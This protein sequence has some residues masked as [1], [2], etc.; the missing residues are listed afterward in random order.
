M[1]S[2]AVTYS[3][4]QPFLD[5]LH[6]PPD[7]SSLWISDMNPASF[8]LSVW[9]RQR[10]TTGSIL[11]YLTN[12]FFFLIFHSAMLEISA[13]HQLQLVMFYCQL[14]T[15]SACPLPQLLSLIC[16]QTSGPWSSSLA[17]FQSSTSST[18]QHQHHGSALSIPSLNHTTQFKQ[19][20]RLGQDSVCVCVCVCVYAWVCVP[21]LP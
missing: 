15:K 1:Y 21:P 2:D 10:P 3:I 16:L 6:F 12:N 8:C 11:H 13:A 5:F 19:V 7:M 14:H 4:T 18:L 9:Y 20:F 17:H